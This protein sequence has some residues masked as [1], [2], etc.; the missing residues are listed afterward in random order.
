MSDNNNK[1]NI[2]TTPRRTSGS[3]V[4]TML[5]AAAVVLSAALLLP[6][7]AMRTEAQ[8]VSQPA[9]AATAILRLF[10]SQ[11]Y[12]RLANLTGDA[13]VTH[14]LELYG[15]DTRT[16]LGRFQVTVPAKG[17]I[18]FSPRDM[19]PGTRPA[20]LDQF[21][22]LY[23]D[24]APAGQFWQ[25]VRYDAANGSFSDATVCATGDDAADR[26]ARPAAAINVHTDRIGR[27]ASFVTV[28]NPGV[29]PVSLQARLTH[30]R[31]GERIG[32]IAIDLPP[33]GTHSASGVWYQL[34]G[35]LFIPTAE[36]QHFNVEFV[37]ADGS[38]PPRLTVSHEVRDL[39][40]NQ[41]VNLSMLCALG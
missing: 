14:T 10:P 29:A 24:G 19:V 2:T 31:T 21:M 33:R 39:L 9:P 36:Q 30:A 17:S 18:Q 3:V 5:Y 34:N 37:A 6:V 20:D 38:A 32:T 15:L 16:T 13:P 40:A 28:H 8:T 35:G 4:D 41:S 27:Y 7:A 22:A 23:I 12:V 11:S 26:G 25:H 1:N